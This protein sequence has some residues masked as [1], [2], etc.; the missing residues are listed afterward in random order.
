MTETFKCD[1]CT[2]DQPHTHD[3]KWIPATALSVMEGQLVRLEHGDGSVL[4]RE[5]FR[6][7]I[8]GWSKIPLLIG[9][10]DS[11]RYLHTMM[12]HGW[13]LFVPAPTTPPLPTEP[14]TLWL[15]R[16]NDVW[17]VARNG[18][19]ICLTGS[20]GTHR[21]GEGFSHGDPNDYAP[22]VRLEPRADTAKA[23]LE[24]VKSLAEFYADDS[25]RYLPLVA[26]E[27]GV[28]E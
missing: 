22:F 25:T 18:D 10:P 23:V 21:F 26:A 6:D 5:S 11:V 17:L 24:R 12:G 20:M 19:L 4:I 9:E 14:R 3:T 2:F 27:F 16:T 8:N 1:R 13:S 28:T 15:D 7:V